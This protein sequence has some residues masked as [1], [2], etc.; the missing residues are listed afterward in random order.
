LAYTKMISYHSGFRIARSILNRMLLKGYYSEVD[1]IIA[2]IENSSELPLELSSLDPPADCED[3]KILDNVFID[4]E[5]DQYSIYSFAA[6]SPKKA[7][8]K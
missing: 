1:K 6:D 4:G 2:N 3:D 8:E 7:F 5:E